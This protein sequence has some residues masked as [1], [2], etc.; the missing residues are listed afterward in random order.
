[1]MTIDRNGSNSGQPELQLDDISVRFG[2]VTAA[3]GVSFEIAPGEILGLIGPNGAGKS[4]LLNV[5]SGFVRPASGT[6][7]FRG[8]SI[9]RMAPPDRARAG[10]GRTFQVA[11]PF[12][13][14]TVEQNLQVT[15]RQRR[16]GAGAFPSI[17][18]ALRLTGTTR[19]SAR[20]VGRLRS[21]ERRFVELARAL[22]LQPT[23]LLLDEPATGL[24][25]NETEVLSRVLRVLQ[26][27]HG[28]ASLVVSHDMR[29]VN[30]CCARVVVM[31]QGQVITIGSPSEIRHHPEVVQAY[32]GPGGV[33][34]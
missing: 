23:V 6:V 33:T 12:V 25:S 9:N 31:D 30:N 29:L 1:M 13:G 5:V 2:G 11:R 15:Q 19:L 24:R 7:A 18:D 28:I 17:A 34:T 22:M 10:I 8:S 16:R 4:T 14:L 27:E 3:V 21:G 26:A 32:F 20:P